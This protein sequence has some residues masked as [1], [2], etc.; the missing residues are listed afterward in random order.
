[1][2]RRRVS[3]G[4]VL[5]LALVW[6][7]LW[8]RLSWG[9]V[10]AGLAIGL[11]VTSVFR[12]SPVPFGVRVRPWGLAVLVVRFGVDL[13]VAS[14]EVA[15]LALRPGHTP[16]G[17]V[18]RVRLRG[19]SDLF[20]TLT[21]ELVS[22]VPGSLVVEARRHT[23]ELY[24]HVLDLEHSGG[25]EAVRAR[26]LAQEERVL[27]ALASPADLAAAGLAETRTHPPRPVA[28]ERALPT[29]SAPDASGALGDE[30]E[31]S[32]PGGDER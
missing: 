16:H 6:V 20:L 11:V 31:H 14:F 17:A 28:A 24:L 15:A 9:N 30:G 13:L 19:H 8:G 29:A 18:I 4:A 25:V 27:R 2:T 32:A 3:W 1:V 10:A 12:M 26:A 5:W 23:G 21:A 22:L 7:L